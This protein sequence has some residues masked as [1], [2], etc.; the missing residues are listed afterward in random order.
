MA[1]SG[2]LACHLVSGVKIVLGIVMT[3]ARINFSQY[4]DKNSPVEL[5]C[6]GH[7]ALEMSGIYSARAHFPAVAKHP[8]FLTDQ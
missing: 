8:T 3:H 6:P 4:Q 1:D 5:Y 7:V 2:E